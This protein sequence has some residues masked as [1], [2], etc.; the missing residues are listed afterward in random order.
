MFKLSFYG[1]D[2]ERYCCSNTNSKQIQIH[3]VSQPNIH[4]LHHLPL[5]VNISP[6]TCSWQCTKSCGQLN[7]CQITK[8]LKI[9]TEITTEELLQ[10]NMFGFHQINDV[11]SKEI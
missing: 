2:L 8:H 1:L 9:E 11:L 3:Y 5:N 6:A 4:N 7:Q 10:C